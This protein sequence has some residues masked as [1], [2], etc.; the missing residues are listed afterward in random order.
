MAVYVDIKING[1]NGYKIKKSIID[2]WW[3]CFVYDN[4]HEVELNSV[5]PEQILRASGHLERFTDD[6]IIDVNGI[7]H[8]ADHYAKKWFTDNNLTKLSE[9]VD[10]WTSIELENMIN[11]YNMFGYTVNVSKKNL[12][13]KVDED[14]YLR[15]E[16]AQGIFVNFDQYNKYL[17][18]SD[19]TFSQ[20]GIARIGH[21]YRKEISPE[22]NIRMKE[23]TQAD[24]EYFVDPL[25]KNHPYYDQ[26]SDTVIPILSSQMQAEGSSD[27]SFMTIDDAVK[28]GIIDNTV[29]AYFIGKIYKFAIEVGLKHDAIRFRQHLPNEMSH[30]AIQCFDL[31]T[32]VRGDWL[33]CVGCADRG[34]HDLLCHKVF[35]SR[36]L[37]ND[38]ITTSEYQ[39]KPIVDKLKICYTKELATIL[40]YFSTISSDNKATF[41]EIVNSS[42]NREFNI[43]ID[44]TVFQV[45]TRYV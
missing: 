33:E 6:V 5:M 7:S 20:F 9:C 1:I 32:Y 30:Y 37:S 13:M 39:I 41:I 17:T 21:S 16:L 22:I 36:L 23:F 3:R 28:N 4:I 38:K 12:M 40:K 8:R 10:N 19:N 18:N 15:P 14:N 29:M 35:A 26:V 25:D 2:E 31:E 44:G 43:E 11:K 34:Q 27:H 42:D 24:I 45:I